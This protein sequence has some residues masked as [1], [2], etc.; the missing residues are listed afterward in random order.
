MCAEF[1]MELALHPG[2]VGR[3]DWRHTYPN[4][5]PIVDHIQN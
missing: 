4:N 2:T 1:M 5:Y 3:H